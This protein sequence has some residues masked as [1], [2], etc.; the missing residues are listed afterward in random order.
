VIKINNTINSNTKKYLLI[1]TLV[2]ILS[3]IF[4]TTISVTANIEEEGC[5]KSYCSQTRESL[6]P[7]D[8]IEGECDSFTYCS[9]GCCTDPRGIRHS[10]YLKGECIRKGGS[11]IMEDCP[12]VTGCWT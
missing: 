1:F 4:A 11:F 6:C 10:K 8:W 3:I 7:G 5:C 9:V 12:D 2:S